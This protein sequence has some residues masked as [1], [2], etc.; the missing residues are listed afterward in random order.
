MIQTDRIVYSRKENNIKSV[1]PAY[2]GNWTLSSNR[3]LTLRFCT[4]SPKGGGGES[5]RNWSIWENQNQNQI[6]G[7]WSSLSD[8]YWYDR[9][10]LKAYKL[11]YLVF[12]VY[13]KGIRSGALPSHREHPTPITNVSLWE[14]TRSIIPYSPPP[15]P[16]TERESLETA[17]AP[18]AQLDSLTWAYSSHGP[19]TC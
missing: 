17:P 13:R 18:L 10:K 1:S 6:F 3:S 19:A 14:S 9:K 15:P 16:T 5:S 12:D 7:C 4:M 2:E 11:G 8:N